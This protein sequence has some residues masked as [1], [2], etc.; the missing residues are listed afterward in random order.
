MT[1]TLIDI[2]KNVVKN[3]IY[4]YHSDSEN[5]K[6]FKEAINGLFDRNLIQKFDN[7]SLIMISLNDLVY[8]FDNNEELNKLL[9][10]YYKLEGLKIYQ[11]LFY[12]KISIL[13][14]IFYTDDNIMGDRDYN[15]FTITFNKDYE[16]LQGVMYN[17]YRNQPC[18]SKSPW[19]I[20]KE[21][22]LAH[23]HK[24]LKW[25]KYENDYCLLYTIY[26]SE[27]LTKY[28]DDMYKQIEDKLEENKINE[29][30]NIVTEFRKILLSNTL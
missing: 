18:K 5:Y 27:V 29:I 10:K 20:P 16:E 11:N 19:M 22:E 23:I 1:D 15:N 3:S 6:R 24:I 25:C 13:Y 30:K 14:N 28:F 8:T 17:V 26:S 9:D 21:C 12:Y 7:T 4:L 2:Y